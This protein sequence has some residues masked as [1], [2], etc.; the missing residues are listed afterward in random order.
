MSLSN[1]LVLTLQ[2]SGN[3]QDLSRVLD[4]IGSEPAAAGKPEPINHPLQALAL[5]LSE[6]RNE[7]SGALTAVRVNG[8]LE[9]YGFRIVSAK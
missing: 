7:G 6:A 9:R 1:N 3:S 8:F 4:S 5:A 2:M